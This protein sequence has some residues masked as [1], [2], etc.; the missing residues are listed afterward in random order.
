MDELSGGSCGWTMDGTMDELS[1]GSCGWTINGTMDELS[2]DTP[3]SA[4]G[5]PSLLLMPVFPQRRLRF[6]SASC[7]GF[8]V[9]WTFRLAAVA[10]D[11][12]PWM[13]SPV[14]AL[15]GLWIG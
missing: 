8:A 11:V 9:V 7:F 3:A 4:H 10:A 1:G 6:P 15:A 5:L 14:A 13:S 12:G 2:G